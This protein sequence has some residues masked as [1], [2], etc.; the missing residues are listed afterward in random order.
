[1]AQTAATSPGTMADD[2]SVGAD[3]WASPNNAKVS[4]NTRSQASAVSGTVISH[5]LKAT[6]FG[7]TIPT[8]ATINGILV[9][10]E[11]SKQG[12]GS[13][14][15]V[16][17]EVKIVK[18]DGSIGTTN[19]ADVSTEWPSTASETYISYGGS[20][21][22]WGESWTYS[23]INNSNFGIVI[24][25]SMTWSNPFSASANVDHIR[26]TI[27]YTEVATGRQIA[28][29]RTIATRTISTNR[30]IASARTIV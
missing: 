11:K 26:I 21:D 23:D 24:S 5:Y 6:N 30:T 9:E 14:S 19:K 13:P 18:S 22:L 3:D 15:V 2:A 17:S 28:S 25:T 29:T 7:F 20:S 4:D 10:I 8:N 1:M 12:S 16:D 27:T